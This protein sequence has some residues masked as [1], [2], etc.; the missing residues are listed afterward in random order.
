MAIHVCSVVW[1]SGCAPSSLPPLPPVMPQ[2]LLAPPGISIARSGF[3]DDVDDGS[4][5]A[6]GKDGNRQRDHGDVDHLAEGGQGSTA[7]ERSARGNEMS[8]LGSGSQCMRAHAVQVRTCACAYACAQ[9]AW[10]L[11]SEA[12]QAVGLSET[13]FSA[14]A[15][16]ASLSP[17]PLGPRPVPSLPPLTPPPPWGRPS[18][19]AGSP[20]T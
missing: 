16:C 18:A 3:V 17:C 4:H 14:L 20:S 11:R 10:R 7:E 19:R 8:K 15:S 12:S 6:D 13:T 9:H 5:R 1:H 2:R